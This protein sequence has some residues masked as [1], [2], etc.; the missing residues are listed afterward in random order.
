MAITILAKLMS[1]IT[2][3]GL[4][5]KAKSQKISGKSALAGRASKLLKAK[6]EAPDQKEKEREIRPRDYVP[7]PY[8]K[9]EGSIHSV[10]LFSLTG[11]VDDIL[12]AVNGP[13]NSLVLA[14]QNIPS[15]ALQQRKQEYSRAVTEAINAT[16]QSSG[17]LIENAQ[18][19]D[20]VRKAKAFRYVRNQIVVM[21][22]SDEEFEGSQKSSRGDYEIVLLSKTVMTWE[23]LDLKTLGLLDEV[24]TDPSRIRKLGRNPNSRPKIVID[25]PNG[26]KGLMI[27]TDEQIALLRKS[28]IFET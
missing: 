7:K 25:K 1:E 4:R 10:N 26:N 24:K 6:K 13:V 12:D 21:I 9:H 18:D 28:L 3:H 11:E 14:L 8:G 23:L 19:V 22:Y 20:N 17:G 15:V 16:Q 5:D 27:A 2:N